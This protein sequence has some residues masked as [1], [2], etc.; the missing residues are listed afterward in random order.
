MIKKLEDKMASLINECT[1]RF[2]LERKRFNDR[3]VEVRE[4]EGDLDSIEQTYA[5]LVKFIE[6]NMAAKVLLRINEINNFIR[7]SIER[8]EVIM[9]TDT[10]D[11]FVNPSLKPIQLNVTRALEAIGK[12][13]VW[14]ANS[15]DGKTSLDL[16][17]VNSSIVL[18]PLT[19]PAPLGI[20][21]SAHTL[22]Q[23]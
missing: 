9:R 13:T 18:Q 21:S 8:L 3:L 7:K 17:K 19:A 4:M 2:V 1:I 16:N 22:P 11:A 12:F 6:G 15:I 23:K 20:S 14:N 10:S 5:E